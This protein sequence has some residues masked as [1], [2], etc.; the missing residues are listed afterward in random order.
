MKKLLFILL[1]LCFFLFPAKT[2]AKDY[3]IPSADFRVQLYSDG[4]A[5]VVETRTY[6]FDGSFSWADEWIILKDDAKISDI[7]VREGERG[8][9][10]SDS[11]APG[12]FQL[13]ESSDR[14]YLKW[15]YSAL[16]SDKTFTLKYHIDNAVTVHSDIAEFYW[17]LVGDEWVKATG[18]VNAKVFLAS[19]AP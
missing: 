13:S 2:L 3:S 5:D 17:Q 19:P 6:S 4:S 7:E 8:Y 15:F 14:I 16:D 9:A 12:S 11:E 18:Q 10:L 1:F